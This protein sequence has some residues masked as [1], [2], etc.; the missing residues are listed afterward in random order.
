[1]II[2]RVYYLRS[3]K[4]SGKIA[5]QVAHAVAK[6][7]KDNPMLSADKVIV[8]KASKTKMEGF[9]TINDSTYTQF[10]LGY[11]EECALGCTLTPYILTAI[12][13]EEDFY[14]TKING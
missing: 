1:M 11:T 13:W 8:L 10:D 7:Q 5:S 2:L 12:C 4:D 9:L 14:E 6:W 3:L